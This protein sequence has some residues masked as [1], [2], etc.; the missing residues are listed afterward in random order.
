MAIAAS[1]FAT[2]IDIVGSSSATHNITVSNVAAGDLVCVTGMIFDGDDDFTISVADDKGNGTYTMRSALHDTGS[3]ARTYAYC[4]FKENVIGSGTFTL[5][6]TIT[7]GSGA[8]NLY[9]S[10]GAFRVTDAATSS[11]EAVTAATDVDRDTSAS[12]LSA[13]TGTLSQADCLA[14]AVAGITTGSDAN[15]NFGSPA[16]WTNRYRQNDGVGVGGLDVAT[17]VVS[18]TSALTASWTHDNNTNDRGSAVVVVFKQAPAA[19]GI[20][21]IRA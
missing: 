5:T 17:I 16:G 7:G 18:S 6:L 19:S 14:V 20:F 12:D 8:G 3:P 10:F 21:Y 1:D 15:L 9:G 13:T 4:A 2:R 11:V